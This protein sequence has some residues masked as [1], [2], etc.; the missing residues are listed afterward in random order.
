MKI[1]NAKIAP[2]NTNKSRGV[3]RSISFMF[4]GVHIPIIKTFS[5][6]SA[7]F[8]A[9]HPC[10]YEKLG[11]NYVAEIEGKREYFAFCV[12]ANHFDDIENAVYH[13]R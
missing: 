7:K 2:S 12:V 11:S 4:N 8:M 1:L 6:I 13:R 3:C 10:S 5:R 9:K